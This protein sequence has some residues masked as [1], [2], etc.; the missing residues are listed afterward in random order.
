[1]RIT[2][3]ARAACIILLTLVSP[4]PSPVLPQARDSAADA[5]IG[6]WGVEESFGPTA[7]GTLTID[8]RE[9]SWRANIAGYAATVQRNGESVRFVLP[10]GAGEFRGHLTADMQAIFGHWIEPGGEILNNRYA[11][12]VTLSLLDKSIWR[13]N[14]TPL[15]QRISL[16]ISVER[17]ASGM[18][19]AFISDPVT[20]FFRRRQYTV[21][22]SGTAV[23]LTNGNRVIRGTF[24][25]N[26]DTL[27]LTVV[28]FM[29][30]FR[31]SRR[32]D[33]DAIGF[34]PRVAQDAQ[35]YVYRRPIQ[36]GDGWATA[37]LDEVGLDRRLISAL[38]EKI[39][40]ADLANNPAYIQSLLIA[41]HGRLALEEYF[42]GFSEARTHDTRSAGKTL[43]TILAGI[44]RDH[45]AKLT[46]DTPV[47]S[48][49]PQY[50]DAFANWDERKRRVRLRDIMSMTAGNA[51]DDND[52]NSPG[53]EDQM[54]QQQA[55]PD[56][57]KY[58][59]D[60][61]M[62]RDPGEEHAI[63]CS[64]DLNL[65]GGAV[66]SATGRWLPDLFDEYLA[67]P[68]QFGLY[69]LNLTPTGDAYMGGGAY[70][71]PRDEL[72]IG[73]LYLAGGVWNGRRVVSEDWVKESTAHHSSFTP[74]MP[75]EG[76][77]EYGYGWH[78][79][80]L[81]L[82]NRVF[83]DYAAEGNGGQF[84]IVVPDLDLVVGING[85]SYGEF[86]KWYRWEFDLVPQYVLAAT[87]NQ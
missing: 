70:L 55:Q 56:W 23:T 81:R 12:P 80:H 51:C 65:V 83:R 41:R 74:A 6:V 44:A 67:R 84:V 48:L 13:G 5:L 60:L 2:A 52:D 68:L 18:L 29:P 37:S 1:M 76:A 42:Y 71:R 62:L 63:Y 26:S 64:A 24:D 58:T 15:E 30:S 77:H 59:L 9:K 35:P 34:Y 61:P 20:N 19:T 21:A 69:H 3:T 45:G 50:H 4:G 72:K 75:D 38:V 17:D 39:L 27:T 86:A 78:I 36:T 10:D 46:P 16:Y 73:Q 40:S 87:S 79:H 57:Y 31:F 28:D 14:V 32:R 22:R 53:N 7:R 82:G 66:A 43:A 54:Q 25:A 47:Y 33:R 85:G 49:F 11:T 8:G